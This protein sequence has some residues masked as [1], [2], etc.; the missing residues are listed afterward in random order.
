MTID[1]IF[2]VGLAPNRLI[3]SFTRSARAIGLA[4]DMIRDTGLP[5]RVFTLAWSGARWAWKF[6]PMDS[7]QKGA[8]A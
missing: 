7:I 6:Q 3:A 2:A 1:T 4:Q 5:Y 8:S